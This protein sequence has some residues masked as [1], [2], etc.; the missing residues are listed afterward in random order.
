MDKKMY[1]DGFQILN[2]VACDGY[3]NYP[4]TSGVAIAKGDAIILTTGFAA[5]GTTLATNTFAGIAAGENTA[6]EAS[7][8][9]AVSIAVIPP[10]RQYRFMVP[11]TASA[12]LADTDVGQIF[13]LDGSED[14]IAESAALTAQWGFFVD[15]I[16]ISTETVAVETYGYAHGHFT[17]LSTT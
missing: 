4:V 3:I 6:A 10:L 15:A 7:S 8:D 16:D 13:N 11:C 12:I 5:L 1:M 9:G 2:E 17:L 14:G